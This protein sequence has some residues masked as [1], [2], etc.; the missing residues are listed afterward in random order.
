M[1]VD[2]GRIEGAPVEGQEA[3]RNTVCRDPIRWRLLRK[4][5]VASLLRHVHPARDCDDLHP[6][7]LLFLRRLRGRR[8]RRPRLLG[9]VVHSWTAAAADVELKTASQGTWER[10]QPPRRACRQRPRGERWQHPFVQTFAT[11]RPRNEFDV[12]S[13]GVRSCILLC[14]MRGASKT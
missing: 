6:I 7:V 11:G 4:G 12:N 9:P 1:W 2:A 8:A 13:A 3:R 5:P 10:R 14:M